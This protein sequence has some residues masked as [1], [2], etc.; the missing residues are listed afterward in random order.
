VA[1]T[2]LLA[3]GRIAIVPVDGLVIRRTLWRLRL[4]R[5]AGGISPASRELELLLDDASNGDV[6]SD[7]TGVSDFVSLDRERR[8]EGGDAQRL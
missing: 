2:D 8:A 1:A 7:A 4:H 5:R 6:A 3:L